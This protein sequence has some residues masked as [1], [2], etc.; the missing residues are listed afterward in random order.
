MV[1]H[2]NKWTYYVGYC[3]WNIRTQKPKENADCSI[4]SYIRLSQLLRMTYSS[5]SGKTHYKN[6]ISLT[7]YVTSYITSFKRLTLRSVEITFLS[8]NVEALKLF[9]VS[10]SLRAVALVTSQWWLPFAIIYHFFMIIFV[11]VLRKFRT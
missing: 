9:C 2:S 5:H 11:I 4:S 8:H 7:R 3:I 10:S 1:V 6:G